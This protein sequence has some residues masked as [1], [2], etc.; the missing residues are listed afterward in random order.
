MHMYVSIV[1]R[2]RVIPVF[3]VFLVVALAGRNRTST[4]N[5]LDLLIGIK[6]MGGKTDEV[7]DLFSNNECSVV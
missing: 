7:P 6:R 3:W 5:S 2:S 1:L 4:A